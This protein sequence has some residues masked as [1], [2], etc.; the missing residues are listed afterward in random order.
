MN[1]YRTNNKKR[2]RNSNTRKK[3]NALAK[4]VTFSLAIVLIFTVVEF[5]FSIK[6]G[7]THDT[8]TTCVYGFWGGEIVMAALIKIFK[9]R[10]ED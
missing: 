7:I 2:K 6:T 1:T 8:L 9:I 5:V 4:Y 3:D 10:K